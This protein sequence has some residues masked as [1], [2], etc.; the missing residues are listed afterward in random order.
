[1]TLLLDLVRTQ[2][3]FGF[4]IIS[5]QFIRYSMSLSWNR[6]PRTKSRI[7]SNLLHRRSKSMATSS[8]K[9]QQSSTPRSTTDGDVNCCTLSAGQGTRVQM[10]KTHGCQLLNLNMRRNSYRTST[11]DT[12]TNP[13]LDQFTSFTHYDANKL[14]YSCF[15]FSTVMCLVGSALRGEYCYIR[16]FGWS[17]QSETRLQLCSAV[18]L[19]YRFIVIHITSRFTPLINTSSL[20]TLL[21]PV[22]CCPRRTFSETPPRYLLSIKLSYFHL[23]YSVRISTKSHPSPLVHL[24]FQSSDFP[25]NSSPSLGLPRRNSVL[26]PL[27][28]S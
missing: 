5:V 10:R 6:Q 14:F 21:R 28:L 22:S 17:F 3:H 26:V 24:K 1:M 18:R 27:P 4:P 11:R 2:L 13:V 20:V 23:Y 15:W 8:T 9:L 12:Q 16:N 25:R 7:V 19:Y